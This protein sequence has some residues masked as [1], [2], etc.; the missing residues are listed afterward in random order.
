M[1][2]IDREIKRF[3]SAN[4]VIAQVGMKA[5]ISGYGNKF[6]MYEV[7]GV[8]YSDSTK[9][10]YIELGY[11]ASRYVVSYD[12]YDFKKKIILTE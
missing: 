4:G 2:A 3:I 12:I 9:K 10:Y 6:H 1:I 7:K 11:P 8:R 5:W